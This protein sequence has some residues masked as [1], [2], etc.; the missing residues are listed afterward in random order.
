MLWKDAVQQLWIRY[1]L[2]PTPTYQD[3]EC[4]CPFVFWYRSWNANGF[5]AAFFIWSIRVSTCWTNREQRNM[6]FLTKETKVRNLLTRAGNCYPRPISLFLY[7]LP[8][9]LMQIAVFRRRWLTRTTTNGRY[10][11]AELSPYPRPMVYD[12]RNPL[13][14]TIKFELFVH[15]KKQKKSVNQ[16][17]NNYCWHFAE[18]GCHCFLKCKIVKKIYWIAMSIEHM[19]V[20]LLE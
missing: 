1:C 18:D 17:W 10:K 8:A 9:W 4:R 14:L 2:H 20:K 7:K 13:N 15:R 19:K 5:A 16:R 12:W 3:E 11:W 6:C